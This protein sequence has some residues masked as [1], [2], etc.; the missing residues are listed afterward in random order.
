MVCRMLGN[1]MLFWYRQKPKNCN[2]VSPTILG[3]IVV[4]REEKGNHFCARKLI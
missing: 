3:Q 1:M 2:V 4:Q